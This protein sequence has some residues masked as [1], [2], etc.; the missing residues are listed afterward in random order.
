[1]ASLRISTA[2]SLLESLGCS[3][4]P[5]TYKGEELYVRELEDHPKAP[6]SSVPAGRLKIR[7]W[8]GRGWKDGTLR[9]MAVDRFNY[10]L[11]ND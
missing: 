6:S 3:E 2:I 4:D 8:H 11:R 7:Y 1:M 9:Q 10:S 5:V